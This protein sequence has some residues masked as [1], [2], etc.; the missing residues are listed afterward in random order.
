[1]LR[2]GRGHPRGLVLRS[3]AELERWRFYSAG[4]GAD[5]DVDTV[6]LPLG[7]ALREGK[8]A[9]YFEEAATATV[10]MRRLCHPEPTPVDRLRLELDELFGDGCLLA[11]FHAAA[12]E[13]GGPELVRFDG[14]KLKPAIP[15]VMGAETSRRRAEVHPHWDFRQGA[16]DQTYTGLLSAN[17]YLRMP[18]RGGEFE[19]WPV[20]GV[21]LEEDLERVKA[22]GDFTA[23]SWRRFADHVRATLPPPWLLTP[24]AGDLVLINTKFHAV[25]GFDRGWRVSLQTFIDRFEGKPLLLRA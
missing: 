8:A 9:R 14:R 10:T 16:R 4:G 19:L 13:A 21:S 17:V 2:A 20:P 24:A 18:D 25:R 7:V 15:R 1:V 6:G 11:T 12:A 22:D 5:N 23:A 3:P